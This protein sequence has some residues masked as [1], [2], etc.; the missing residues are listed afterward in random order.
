M[1]STLVCSRLLIATIAITPVAKGGR[2]NSEL[3]SP[4][5]FDSNHL[6]IMLQIS[7]RLERIDRG[8]QID[9]CNFG[10]PHIYS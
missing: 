1:A 6:L 5:M 8:N 2:A 9:I 3:V 4:G 10:A 7:I